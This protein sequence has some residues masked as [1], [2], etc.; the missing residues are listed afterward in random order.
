[1]KMKKPGWII[2]G[3]VT[4]V[5]LLLGGIWLGYT[6]AFGYGSWGMMG[7]R[8]MMGGYWGS[9][10][11]GFAGGLGMLMFWALVIG[12]IVWLVATVSRSQSQT[13]APRPAGEAPLDVLKRRYAAGEINKEQFDEM[14]R[15]LEG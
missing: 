10:M 14:R 12:G 13:G 4:A 3:I 2:L 9:P 11:M 7:G 15:N 5:A 8:N 1:M 6:G